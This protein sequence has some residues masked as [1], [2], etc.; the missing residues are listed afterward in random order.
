MRTPQL[1]NGFQMFIFEE[2]LKLLNAFTLGE[3]KIARLKDDFNGCVMKGDWQSCLQ[4]GKIFP[5]PDR[6][7]KHLSLSRYIIEETLN[8]L[9]GAEAERTKPWQ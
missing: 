9:S 7:Q 8:V 4:I 3:K 2:K 1:I 6:T 5:A